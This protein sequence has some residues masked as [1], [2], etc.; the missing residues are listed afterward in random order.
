MN[1]LGNLT[2]VHRYNIQGLQ[3]IWTIKSR[4]GQTVLGLGLYAPLVECM[5]RE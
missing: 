5:G 1:E 3:W 4:L 2:L